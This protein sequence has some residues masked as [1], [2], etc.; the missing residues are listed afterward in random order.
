MMRR[1]QPDHYAVLQ[2][3]PRASQSEIAAA[4]ERLRELYSAERTAE[5]APELQTLAAE[6]R[7]QIERAYQALADESRRAAYDQEQGFA[8]AADPARLDYAPLP[9]ARGRE[10]VDVVVAAE[11]RQ[12]TQRASRRRGPM[13]W[14]LS[15]GMG[16][17]LVAALL[18][19]LLS[20]V[21]TSGGAAALATPTIRGV[22]LPFTDLQVQQFRSAAEGNNTAESWIALGN[23]LFDNLQ[24]LREQAPLSPQYRGLLQGWLD[25]AAA[26]ERALALQESATVRADRAVAL[27]NYGQDAPDPRRVA[28]AVAEVERG[29]ANGV[30]EPRALINY[31]L[32]L[33]QL[34]PPR[35]EEAFAAWRKVREVAPQSPEAGSAER[36]LR[37]YGQS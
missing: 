29:L 21:R 7:G 22:T 35:R 13:A 4:Y 30:N 14:L 5:A 33:A 28:D 8:P 37:S 36:L 19:V 15:L 32:I 34:E 27:F 24:T 16:A 12:P 23:A 18:L 11:R 1:E 3:S 2:V 25:V 26:Y 31:G 10:R 9:P 20:G 17:A 6:K